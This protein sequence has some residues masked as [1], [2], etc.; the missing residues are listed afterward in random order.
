MA[1]IVS[2]VSRAGGRGGE[3]RLAGRSKSDEIARAST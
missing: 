2:Q 3:G 1:G